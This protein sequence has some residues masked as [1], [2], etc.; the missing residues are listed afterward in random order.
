MNEEIV[1]SLTTRISPLE[2]SL[3]QVSHTSTQSIMKQMVGLR[4][5]LDSVYKET[6]E[7]VTLT[8]LVEKLGDRSENEII[9]LKT[10]DITIDLN[11]KHELIDLKISPLEKET[12]IL[13]KH[14]AILQAYNNLIQLSNMDLSLLTNYTSSIQD[15]FHDLDRDRRVVL[16]HEDELKELTRVF[17]QV[18]V[19]NML[20]FERYVGIVLRENEFWL[21]T[22]KRIS[23]LERRHLQ[24]LNKEKERAKY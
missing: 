13:L 16:Q 12:L 21:E 14:P 18:V 2:I 9:D 23:L 1:D 24:A 10:E 4:N 15:K 22:E 20:V 11:S 7:F 19:K 6:G 8:N 3:S 5:E 17:H